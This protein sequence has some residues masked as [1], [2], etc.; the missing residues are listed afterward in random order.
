MNGG[1]DNAEG[2]QANG[3]VK[4]SRKDFQLNER[5]YDGQKFLEP[6]F[7]DRRD[8]PFSI[9]SLVKGASPGYCIW[10]GLS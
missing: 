10:K 1:K 7:V 6:A 4:I 5:N 9:F 8:V 2:K 3:L